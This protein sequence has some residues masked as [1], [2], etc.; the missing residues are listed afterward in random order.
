VL[1]PASASRLVEEAIAWLRCVTR[2]VFGREFDAISAASL[3]RDPRLRELVGDAESSLETGDLDLAIATACGAFELARCRWER[4]VGYADGFDDE[5]AAILPRLI[6]PLLMAMVHRYED[7]EYHVEVP[8]LADDRYRALSRLTLG[9]TL[10]EF[11]RLRALVRRSESAIHE[12]VPIAA[13]RDE[14]DFAI[15]TVARQIWRVESVHPDA[16]TWPRPPRPYSPT[17]AEADEG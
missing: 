9:F 11:Q 4:A 15:R 14:V 17:D 6:S 7:W 10:D 3:I 2:E 16:V 1:S 12:G 13:T 5:R 8:E